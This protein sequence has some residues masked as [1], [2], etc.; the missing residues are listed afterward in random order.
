[1]KKQIL[2]YI[3]TFKRINEYKIPQSKKSYKNDKPSFMP[4]Q[5]KKSDKKK[6]NK[7]IRKKNKENDK[8]N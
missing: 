3:C 1:M 8:K 6:N 4:K 7:N 5:P 2:K